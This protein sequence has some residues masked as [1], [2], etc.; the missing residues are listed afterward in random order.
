MEYK[1]NKIGI[2]TLYKY[3]R[4]AVELINNPK[5]EEFENLELSGLLDL[6]D[7]QSNA[8]YAGL[9]PFLMPVVSDGE[10]SPPKRWYDPKA[11]SLLKN[12]ITLHP[13]DRFTRKNEEL[14]PESKNVKLS[15]DYTIKEQLPGKEKLKITQ[16]Y[17]AVNFLLNSNDYLY[18]TGEMKNKIDSWMSAIEFN[19]TNFYPALK[20]IL[21]PKRDK[22][23]KIT[24]PERWNEPL[25]N[26]SQGGLL[27]KYTKLMA[28]TDRISKQGSVEEDPVYAGVVNID[29]KRKINN[30][31]M[32]EGEYMAILQELGHPSEKIKPIISSSTAIQRLDGT[33]Q[34][35][36]S[37]ANDLE[38]RLQSASDGLLAIESGLTP[39]TVKKHRNTDISAQKIV[40]ETGIVLHRGTSYALAHRLR[41]TG[42]DEEEWGDLIDTSRNIGL[43][44]K[45]L[46]EYMERSNTT[47]TGIIIGAVDHLE[48]LV[49]E[50]ALRTGE[51]TRIVWDKAFGILI[52]DARGDLEHA[53]DL[54]SSEY[55]TDAEQFSGFNQE[56]YKVDRDQ[57]F[58]QGLLDPL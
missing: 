40:D 46:L 10:I 25:V 2:N 39:A 57:E 41:E 7:I 47:D 16:I 21:M 51:R 18:K 48:S 36:P 34:I 22:D 19:I 45:K 13:E 8:H 58:L 20:N 43:S 37:T 52:D 9:R 23:Y 56:R 33:R 3:A 53:Y 26:D 32:K 28:S 35:T 29:I 5:R 49:D 30:R 27:V 15:D 6:I 14:S 42:I 24:P 11:Q 54:L 44:T 4:N 50:I 1:P 12:Y 38:E 31:R 17:D 55:H